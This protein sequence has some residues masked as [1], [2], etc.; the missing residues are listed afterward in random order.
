MTKRLFLALLLASAVSSCSDPRSHTQAVYMLVDTSGTYAAEINKAQIIINY[1]LGTLQPGDSLAVARVE[2]RSFSEKDIIAKATFDSRPSQANAQK[3]AFRERIDANLKTIADR[4]AALAAAGRLSDVQLDQARQDELNSEDRK[5][6]GLFQE[7]SIRDNISMSVLHQMTR[8]GIVDR[9]AVRGVVTSYRDRLRVRPPDVEIL[10]S[11]LSGG[12]QQK[13]A[14]AKWLALRPKLL[15]LDEP[16]RGIDVGAKA[17]VHALID[18]LAHE[19]IGIILISSELPEVLNMSDR[20]LVVAEG[21]IVGEL[22]REEATQ[23]RCLELA[24]IKTSR[25]MRAVAGAA[26]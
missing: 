23:E 11:R 22:S 20:I 18:E 2:S 6:Q 8:G 9:A 7:M 4:N 5:L 1:L 24:S 3:R 17:E 26:A 13:V 10:V 16:T 21:E 14:L 12:N 15:I 25:A 19:G